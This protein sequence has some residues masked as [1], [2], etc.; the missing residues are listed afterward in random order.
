[1]PKLV[2]AYQPSKHILVQTLDGIIEQNGMHIDT[3]VIMPR[4]PLRS[5]SCIRNKHWTAAGMLSRLA[6]HI[7]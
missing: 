4:R 5:S 6:A 3:V 2:P 1:M 7:G